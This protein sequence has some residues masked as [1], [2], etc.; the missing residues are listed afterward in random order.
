MASI[1]SASTTSATALNLSGDTTG[2][3][4]LA[5]GATPTTAVTIDA[6]QNVGVGTASPT[7]KLNVVGN[8]IVSNNLTVGQA[9]AGDSVLQVYSIYGGLRVGYN[10][11]NVNYYDA[12]SQIFRNTAG[13]ERMRIDS[14]G[15]LLV[16]TTT[17]SG[18]IAAVNASDVIA[19]QTLVNNGYSNFIGKNLSGSNTFYVSGSGT[20]SAIN[21]TISAISDQRFKENIR[22]LDVGLSKVMELQPRLYDW[23]E[24]K[25]A[26]I[27]NARGFIAQ[28]FEVVFPDLVDVWKEEPPKG[29]EPYKSIRQ[30]LIPVLV[31]AIQELKAIIDTQQT[32][33]TA[34][35]AK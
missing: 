34:L 4:Q 30:D 12:D 7:Q 11:T 35:E 32:R 26:D 22:D 24:G 14:S 31:K 33:I 9:L 19:A 23:K 8:G 29:E 1:I 3:L 15:N 18:K 27:K 16:G 6:S 20:I 10:S 21:T 13:T 5:T 17:A 2:I 28:E 25:G